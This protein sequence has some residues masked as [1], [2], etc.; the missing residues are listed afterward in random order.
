VTPVD[1]Y[2]RAQH[3]YDRDHGAI[4][5]DGAEL[6]LGDL[7]EPDHALRSHLWACLCPECERRRPVYEQ[8]GCRPRPER[9]SD[10]PSGEWPCRCSF[11]RQRTAD[12]S[13]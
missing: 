12:G 5:R 1:A 8:H 7:L 2:F 13:T 9:P 6:T 4:A 11:C 3:R 10:D